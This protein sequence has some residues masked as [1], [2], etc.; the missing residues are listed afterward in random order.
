M[1]AQND[2]SL[3]SVWKLHL[4]IKCIKYSCF[5]P[6]FYIFIQNNAWTP[7]LCFT[8]CEGTYYVISS[9]LRWETATSPETDSFILK[10]MEYFFFIPM[11]GWVFYDEAIR[12]AINVVKLCEAVGCQALRLEVTL[13]HEQHPAYPCTEVHIFHGLIG[14][15]NL[16]NSVRQ[17]VDEA[18]SFLVCKMF[19]HE[20][21]TALLQRG[22]HE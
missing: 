9:I 16:T 19:Y 22:R 13:I 3:L 15:H 17:T 21:M 8:K 6:M 2:R 14:C 5:L 20:L 10:Q 4:I 12:A 7:L 18:V 1:V 11:A